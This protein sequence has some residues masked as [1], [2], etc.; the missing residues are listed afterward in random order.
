MHT[1]HIRTSTGHTYQ[2]KPM[3]AAQAAAYAAAKRRRGYEL[4]LIV[5]PLPVSAETA[6]ERLRSKY[7]SLLARLG[8]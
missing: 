1:V 6:Y 7:R 5:P 3:P 2:S 4:V 8:K